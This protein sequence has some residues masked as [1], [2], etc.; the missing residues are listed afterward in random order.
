MKE[1]SG[2]KIIIQG[3]IDC[4]F[5]ENGK[6]ILLDYKSDYLFDSGDEAELEKLVERYRS[7][8]GLYREALEMIRGTRVEEV[9]LYLFSIGKGIRIY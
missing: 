6:Y 1:I 5:E 3:T 4:Y 2:E 8:L 9:Y 7:Q